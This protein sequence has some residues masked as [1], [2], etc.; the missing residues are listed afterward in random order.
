MRRLTFLCACLFMIGIGIVSAQSKTVSGKVLTAEDESPVIGASIVVVGTSHGTISDVDGNFSI[1]VPNASSKLMVSFIGMKTQEVE[2]KNGITILLEADT[3]ELDE[4]M[5]VAYGTAKKSAFTGSA[6]MVNGDQIDNHVV[7]NVTSTL[8]G[9]MAGVQITNSSGAPGSEPTIRIRG[10]GSISASNSPLIVLDGMPYEGSI[11]SINPQD[12]ESISVLKDAASNAIYGARGANGVV[13]ITTKTGKTKDAQV[14]VDARWGSNSRLIPQYDVI[15]DPGQYYETQYAAMYNSQIYAGNSAYDAYNYAQTNLL[16]GTNGGL[17]YQIFTV[18]NGEKLIGNNGRLNPNATLGYSD[19]EYYYTADNWYN[20]TFHN[21]FRQEYNVNVS[22]NNE[23]L[24]YYASVGYLDDGGVVDNSRMQRYSLRSKTD[25]QAKKWLKIGANLAYSLTD[26][27]TPYYDA[28]TYGSSTSI[29]YLCNTIAP[30][31]PL[32]VRD[33]NG[34]KMYKNG[35]P[36]YDANQTNFTRPAFVGN[37]VRDNAVNNQQSYRDLFSGKAYVNLTPVE[38]LTVSANVGVL[39][40]NLRYNKLYSEFGSQSSTDGAAYVYHSRIFGVNSQYLAQYKTDFGGSDH[41]L[42]V[43]AGYERYLQTEQWLEG[44]NGHLYN[45]YIGELGNANGTDEKT[46]TSYTDRY[47]TQGILARLQYDYDGKYFISGSYRRDASSRFAPGHRWGDFGSAGVAWLISQEDFMNNVDWIDMLKIKASYGVQGN[48]DLGSYYP[49]VD[50]YTTSYS[51]ET[52]KYSV[53]L[54]YQGNED[55]TWETSYALNT[56]VDFELFDKRLNGTAEYFNRKTVDLLYN[57][58]IPA[59]SGI[60]T[61]YVPTNIGAISNQGV[62]VTID[63][64]V[65]KSRKVEW[66]L[67]VNLTHYTN[68]ILELDESVAENG[69]KGS[70]Y[71]R[72]VGGSVYTAYLVQYAGV[73]RETG[74]ALY[75]IDPDNG[76][77]TTTNDYS[78]ANQA[79]CGST[80]PKL[81]G[82]FGTTLSAYGLDLSAQFGFSLGGQIYDGSY[83]AFMHNGVG[84][85]IGTN[86]HTDILKAWTPENP[87]TDVPRLSSGDLS[88]QAITSDRFLTS[89]NYL[90]L[91]NVTLGYTFPKKWMDKLPISSIRIY[92]AGENLFVIS[93]RK[94]LD[95]RYSLSVGSMTAGSGSYASTY[96]ATRTITGGITITF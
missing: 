42:D 1:E 86:W 21:S 82:G 20:E 89:S 90:S 18:P 28:D 11:S 24:N 12:I 66:T 79:D 67:N 35:V 43:L 71:I 84:Q 41:N 77:Y 27:Q 39:S 9:S 76:N 33:A 49:Y 70:Y 85:Q 17:G 13:L 88:G 50:Q 23:R 14:T 54:N 58:P 7:S 80:L 96:A 64:V 87:D 40:S 95:P 36:V 31:Y 72:K 68:K 59:S 65:I 46:T 48:D 57:K 44:F 56:G 81:Y 62:E 22:G 51:T 63:G 8:A 91:N 3:E 61:G 55:L 37:A 4:V 38:G 6:A 52:K 25:Y 60:V 74:E 5:V 26:S 15:T 29:F 47:L 32:Y 92:G 94:G 78:A 16:N 69:I 45:P 2:A 10:I 19:G 83:Q 34:N 53:V 30:I 73:D 93:A 75:Y